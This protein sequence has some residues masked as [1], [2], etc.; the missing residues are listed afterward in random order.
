MTTRTGESTAVEDQGRVTSVRIDSDL[1]RRMRDYA[2]R[3]G[4][5]L[6]RIIEGGI[7]L[8]LENRGA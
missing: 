1:D 5:R 4:V 7:Q 2:C 8:Y 3:E 6:R